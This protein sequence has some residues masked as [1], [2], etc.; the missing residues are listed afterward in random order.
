LCLVAIFT[1]T[2]F[3][4]ILPIALAQPITWNRELMVLV[5]NLLVVKSDQHSIRQVF[6][7]G[8]LTV[9]NYTKSA[10]YPTD[11]FAITAFSPGAYYLR[12]LFDLPT[13]YNVNI[14]VS[15]AYFNDTTYY[16]S[17]GP[18]ELD[19]K[20]TFIP[21]P[22]PVLHNGSPEAGFKNWINKFGQAFPLWVKLLYLTFGLQFFA[23]G[24]LWI[25]RET[26]RRE[27]TPHGLD[28]GEKA[29]LWLDILYKF[30]LTSLV[31]LVTVMGGEFVIL[32]LLR[33]M[34]LINLN[35]LSLWDIFVVGFAF[36]L[37][38]IFYI[39]RLTLE[40]LFDLKPLEDDE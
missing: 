1:L 8:N 19:L 33:F 6:L 15:R 22:Q 17:S 38:A 14:Y 2:I 16:L 36:G 29:F 25:R 26:A 27:S 5:G 30:L 32:F 4:P 34:F 35:L 7:Q 18:S 21:R 37:V 24:G 3:S 31:V 39:I 28:A 23:V 13:D 11:A 40:K 12:V 9:A 10:Q 20:V